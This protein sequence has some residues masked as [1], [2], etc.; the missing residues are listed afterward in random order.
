MAGPVASSHHQSDPLWDTV[1][2][3]LLALILALLFAAVRLWQRF[4]SWVGLGLM[5]CHFT[6]IYAGFIAAMA[7][8]VGAVVCD[9]LS[10][11]GLMN[12]LTI[13]GGGG[14]AAAGGHILAGVVGRLRGLSYPAAPGQA[15]RS[16]SVSNG[17]LDFVYEQIHE[18]LDGKM[19]IQ[20]EVLAKRFDWI[21]VK[22]HMITLIEDEGRFWSLSPELA[23]AAIAEIQA[24]PSTT[25]PG[26]ELQNK[27]T[28]LK[29]AMGV[30]SY[31]RVTSR[32]GAGLAQKTS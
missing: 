21:T 27:I 17:L 26:Q 9:G 7:A 19:Q 2:V 8:I 28:A 22:S 5:K 18:E 1:V 29:A 3:L 31:R 11:W 23:Q 16:Q 10:H 14:G 25:D 30:S 32:L 12:A 6:Y 13:G 15:P 20:M 24:L 4:R